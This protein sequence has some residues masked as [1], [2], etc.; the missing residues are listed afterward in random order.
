MKGENMLKLN[1]EAMCEL[2]EKALKA[3]YLSSIERFKVTDIKSS[4]NLD[5]EITLE[6]DAIEETEEA[7]E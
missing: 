5:Y 1:K 4:Y 6:G 7:T 2:V 3:Y